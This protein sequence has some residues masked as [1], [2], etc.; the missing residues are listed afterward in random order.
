[1]CKHNF[2]PDGGLSISCEDCGMEVSG[3]RLIELVCSGLALEELEA[4]AKKK[5]E[6]DIKAK[7]EK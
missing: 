4:A 3:D 7:T 6:A 1:M 2:T 5:I